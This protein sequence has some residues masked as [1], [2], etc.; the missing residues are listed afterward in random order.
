MFMK[1]IKRE[2]SV[3][4]ESISLK[5]LPFLG[6]SLLGTVVV[7]VALGGCGLFGDEDASVGQDDGVEELSIVV[8]A[9][10]SRIEEAEKELMAKKYAIATERSRLQKER[11]DLSG[12]LATLSKQ[13][14]SQRAKLEATEKRL[15]EEEDR[16]RK[17]SVGIDKERSSLEKDKT[18]LLQENTRLVDQLKRMNQNKGGMSTGQREEMM[19]R[20]EDSVAR[21]EAKIIG[22]EKEVQKL[23][24]ESLRTLEAIQAILV[25]LQNSSKMMPS[26]APIIVQAPA[27]VAGAARAT[28]SQV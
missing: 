3:A 2:T 23:H 5:R 9:D 28:K 13:D 7:S 10:S 4:S 27:P 19:T 25:S 15:S 22:E 18:K 12:K 16:L 14:K 26:A 11:A 6:A 21:R 8:E 17:R 24:K 20:R 1:A